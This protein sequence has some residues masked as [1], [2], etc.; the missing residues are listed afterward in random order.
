MRIL[1]VEDEPDAARMV[2][3]GL[4]EQAY[5][6]DVVGDGEAACY[7]AQIADYDA[8]VLDMLLPLKNGLEV[9]RQLRREGASVP[10]LML[11]AR[12]SVE[13]RIA[14]LDGGADD[15]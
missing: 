12:D 10:I 4:H 8:I 14:G 7:Q 3:K 5:A 15:T 6:V 13:A 2:A 1:L 9:C 11:T